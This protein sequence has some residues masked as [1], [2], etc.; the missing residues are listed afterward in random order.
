MAFTA[1]LRSVEGVGS[2]DHHEIDLVISDASPIFF[3]NKTGPI[4]AEFFGAPVTQL[5]DDVGAGAA[6]LTTQPC[7]KDTAGTT[8]ANVAQAAANTGLRIS[9]STIMETATITAVSLPLRRLDIGGL[10]DLA[11][12]VLPVPG[13]RALRLTKF[14]I[15]GSSHTETDSHSGGGCALDA[16]MQIARVFNNDAKHCLWDRLPLQYIRPACNPSLWQAY[17]GRKSFFPAGAGTC[18]HSACRNLK[19]EHAQRQTMEHITW[20]MAPADTNGIRSLHSNL[21]PGARVEVRRALQG[22]SLR[23]IAHKRRKHEL[24]PNAQYRHYDWL[25]AIVRAYDPV[26]RTAQVSLIPQQVLVAIHRLDCDIEVDGNVQG[27]LRA[28]NDD[29]DGE[30]AC[31]FDDSSRLNPAYETEKGSFGPGSACC[32]GNF[33]VV[34]RVTG[35]QLDAMLVQGLNLRVCLRRAGQVVLDSLVGATPSLLRPQSPAEALYEGVADRCGP[36][37]QCGSTARGWVECTSFTAS[38]NR[39][40]V[41]L[42]FKTLTSQR[43]VYFE[44]PDNGGFPLALCRY[45]AETR[46]MARQACVGAHTEPSGS[47]DMR[48]QSPHSNS[49]S[50]SPKPAN[51]RTGNVVVQA[52]FRCVGRL[53]ALGIGVRISIEDA[54]TLRLEAPIQVFAPRAS[55]SILALPPTAKAVET[56]TEYGE[57]ES[58]PECGVLHFSCWDVFLNGDGCLSLSLSAK[59]G[60]CNVESNCDDFP[61]NNV[62]LRLTDRVLSSVDEWLSAGVQAQCAPM[63]DYASVVQYCKPASTQVRGAVMKINCAVAAFCVTCLTLQVLVLRVVLPFL[64]TLPGFLMLCG[65]AGSVWLYASGS[66][67]QPGARSAMPGKDKTSTPRARTLTWRVSQTNNAEDPDDNSADEV[68]LSQILLQVPA[69]Q[70]AYLALQLRS[71]GAWAHVAEVVEKAAMFA[72]LGRS[73]QFSVDN[74]FETIAPHL[75]TAHGPQDGDRF[76]RQESRS[77]GLTDASSASVGLHIVRAKVSE[78]L[79]LVAAFRGSVLP[80]ALHWLA[81]A[82]STQV[83]LVHMAGVAAQFTR[84]PLW[85]SGRLVLVAVQVLFFRAHVLLGTLAISVVVWAMILALG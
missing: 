20:N 46:H 56:E 63:G 7:T 43:G 64:G 15:T 5:E 6:T 54:L 52:C 42:R 44:D 13:C 60:S 10:F 27:K 28:D 30:K 58:R 72:A 8:D 17:D 11:E 69:S 25:P 45:L 2:Y 53:H 19:C 4:T 3:G 34:L 68:R 47:N 1:Q 22:S 74:E 77:P 61:N 37:V 35:V 66:I 29:L 75:G 81:L 24:N 62:H 9:A 55:V 41:L 26:S 85:A 36:T 33:G 84:N 18:S 79:L 49:T 70:T 83:D 65:C 12:G 16:R 21:R 50:E 40:A 48:P 76:D 38:G 73:H 39:A 71:R 78:T 23:Y 31:G 57:S 59:T 14:A 51:A 80:R 67:R 82:S 32:A